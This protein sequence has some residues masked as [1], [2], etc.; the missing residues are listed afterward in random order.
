MKDGQ[1][2]ITINQQE[3]PTP[4]YF[5]RKREKESVYAH[6]FPTI[7]ESTFE[8]LNVGK[9]NPDQVFTAIVYSCLHRSTSHEW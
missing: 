7:K 1:V 3:K 5:Q 4:A 8:L 9:L 6:S 2:V